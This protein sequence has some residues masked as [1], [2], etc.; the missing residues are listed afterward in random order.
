MKWPWV[1]RTLYDEVVR[2]RDDAVQARVDLAAYVQQLLRSNSVLSEVNERVSDTNQQAMERF[3]KLIEHMMRMDR[4]E[5]GLGEKERPDRPKLEPIP[6]KLLEYVN[7]F[8][9]P[10]TR[11]QM[12]D[13]AYKRHAK[14]Q[15]WYQIVAATMPDGGID[16]DE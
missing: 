3:E 11:K 16:E 9:N 6:K 13:E 8:D 1:S 7:S 5:H 4:V 15:P 2:A 12:R 10:T 14:G